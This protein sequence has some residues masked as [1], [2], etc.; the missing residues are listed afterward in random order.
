MVLGVVLEI[1]IFFD[2]LDV[3]EVKDKFGNCLFE[4]DYVWICVVDN[5]IGIDLVYWDQVFEVFKWLYIC[6]VYEGF[7]IGLV[8]CEKIVIVYGGVIDFDFGLGE[9][10]MFSVYL[11]FGS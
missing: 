5:G 6:E 9:G 2:W 4:L 11:F 3:R 7:G 10:M 1:W 8:F